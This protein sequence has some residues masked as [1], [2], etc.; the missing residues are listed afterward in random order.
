MNRLIALFQ[1]K[2]AL[3][4]IGA[5]L[6]GGS[7]AWIVSTPFNFS[8]SQSGSPQ[9]QTQAG[10]AGLAGET[11]TPGAVPSNT[12]GATAPRATPRPR[13]TRTPSPTATPG[14]GQSITM[15]GRVGTVNL[16]AKTFTVI[17]ISNGVTTTI[18]VTGQTVFQGAATSLSGLYPGWVVNVHGIY[19]ADGTIAASDVNSDN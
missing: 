1:T 4:I 9:F 17:S 6:C 14:V 19:Q 12:P 13:S 18:V 5:V 10:A 15:F 8:P 2:V 16:T 7:A 3:A 11:E